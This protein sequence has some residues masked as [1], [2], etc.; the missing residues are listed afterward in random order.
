MFGKVIPSCAAS[1]MSRRASSLS[2]TEM[3]PP[4]E[5]PSHFGLFRVLVLPRNFFAAL[6]THATDLSS[7]VRS[8]KC[9]I[10][11][12]FWTADPAGGLL[13]SAW[14]WMRSSLCLDPL[15]DIYS[16]S[17]DLVSAAANAFF[18]SLLMLS[19][20]VAVISLADLISHSLPDKLRKT[21]PF[22]HSEFS[23]T[24]WGLAPP[25]ITSA[26]FCGS[27]LHHLSCTVVISWISPI[28]LAK[29]VLWPWLSRCIAP[30]TVWLST[31]WY[32][33]PTLIWLC[34]S[35][36]FRRRENI[37]AHG[38]SLKFRAVIAL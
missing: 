6:Q 24:S 2:L 21:G 38:S 14:T 32:H 31:K 26:M 19:H 5:T 15:V 8:L 13:D 10:L 34:C 16:F 29:N 36:D 17:L 20:A 11:H 1:K 7:L 33:F 25:M 4:E 35:K 3:V 37:I 22:C 12:M 9:S 30:R 18:W 27:G 23:S 28:L